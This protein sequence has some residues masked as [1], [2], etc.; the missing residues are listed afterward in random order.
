[1]I[2]HDDVVVDSVDERA[3]PGSSKKDSRERLR[4]LPRVVHFR[5]RFL[6]DDSEDIDALSPVFRVGEVVL[7]RSQTGHEETY[8]SALADLALRK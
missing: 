4:R 8:C 5:R 6:D 3:E 7:S 2:L 1:V